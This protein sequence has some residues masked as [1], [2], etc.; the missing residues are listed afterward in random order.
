MW[1][2]GSDAS[3][4]WVAATTEEEAKKKALERF[5]PETDV[6]NVSQDEDV[7]DTWFSSSLLPFANF[8][9]PEKVKRQF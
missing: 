6:T 5:G 8:G 7:L 4:K 3:D 9:W 1:K 2:V